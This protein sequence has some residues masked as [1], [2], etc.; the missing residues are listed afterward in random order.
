VL[1]DEVAKAAAELAGPAP[2]VTAWADLLA[3]LGDSAARWA[4]R[5]TA[6]DVGRLAAAFAR[7][8]AARREEAALFS[9]RVLPIRRLAAPAGK[10][11]RLA[12]RLRE[13]AETA[14]RFAD[15]MDFRFLYNPQR[16]LFAIGYHVPREA[17]DQAHYD[18]LASEACLTSFL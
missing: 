3:R 8:V 10:A 5:A 18:L 1:A 17:I 13:L 7:A 6:G 14:R 11:A 9:G 2:D 4:E 15:Q 12:D 16:Q